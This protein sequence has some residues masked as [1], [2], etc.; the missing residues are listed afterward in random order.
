M[1]KNSV[2]E[3]TANNVQ[4]QDSTESTPIPTESFYQ[5]ID[6]N[7]INR[8]GHQ[9][10]QTSHTW[11]NPDKLQT[12]DSGYIAVEKAT[13]CSVNTSEPIAKRQDVECCSTLQTHASALSH[14]ST[15][16]LKTRLRT[17]SISSYCKTNAMEHFSGSD[18][19][20]K[21]EKPTC[22]HDTIS[23]KE[24][25]NH[26]GYVSNNSDCNPDSFI[27][28]S[29]RLHS[30]PCTLNE[31]LSKHSHLD[32]LPS[33]N[34]SYAFVGSTTI[35]SSIKSASSSS[36]C[37]SD[38]VNHMSEVRDD[39][40]EV[41]TTSGDWKQPETD[42][43]NC[44]MKEI[45]FDVQ[46]NL[47][48]ISNND[49]YSLA[50]PMNMPSIEVEN[51]CFHCLSFQNHSEMQ[52]LKNPSLKETSSISRSLL[53]TNSVSSYCTS[54]ELKIISDRSEH[55]EMETLDSKLEEICVDVHFNEDYVSN[56]SSL[57]YKEDVSDFSASSKVSNASFDSR[58]E[59]IIHRKESLNNI[60][61]L[62][63][64]CAR[65]DPV[66]N[67]S[68][69]LPYSDLKYETDSTNEKILMFKDKNTEDKSSYD[70]KHSGH[71]SNDKCLRSENLEE[72]SNEY[73]K[74]DGPMDKCQQ[75]NEFGYLQV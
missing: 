40:N 30:S 2:R 66:F 22:E 16:N 10:S 47:D 15:N 67:S 18:D 20:F 62:Q 71:V 27:S 46:N 41:N 36:D 7:D 39:P 55:P 25:L 57:S 53:R 72:C 56:S 26:M 69:Y 48:Y 12:G 6:S 32:C 11:S 65:V 54:N 45:K 37:K 34:S 50:D 35:T 13:T 31:D 43:T 44:D 17:S 68:T 64:G 61:K 33:E 5:T 63:T 19:S 28:F 42:M 51:Y 9:P 38:E 49:D 58:N 70:K 23:S 24:V 8:P 14:D 60:P 74:A 3:N 4:N 29:S 52:T 73:V 75:I 59:E 1:Q 21:P